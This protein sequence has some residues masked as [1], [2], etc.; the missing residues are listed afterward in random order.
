MG[1]EKNG[2]AS[3]TQ[4]IETQPLQY[5]VS[6]S[7]LD[8]ESHL[9][10]RKEKQHSEFFGLFLGVLYIS[11]IHISWSEHR[12]TSLP[13][14]KGAQESYPVASNN[15]TPGKGSINLEFSDL[16]LMLLSILQVLICWTS[17]EDLCLAR[18]EW[19]SFTMLKFALILLNT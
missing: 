19:H 15:S 4:L 11:S 13:R 9:I 10:R 1:I 14:C 5:L 2:C 16:P 8:F 7:T 18:G 17:S 12:H 3:G 6:K